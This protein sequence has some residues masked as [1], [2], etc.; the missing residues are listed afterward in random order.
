VRPQVCV[1]DSGAQDIPVIQQFERGCQVMNGVNMPKV[2]TLIDSAGLQ[3][4][5]LV[6]VRLLPCQ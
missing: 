1:A 4:K 3:H 6:K 2:V 5:H